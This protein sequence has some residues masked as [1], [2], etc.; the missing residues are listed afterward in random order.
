M[1]VVYVTI[2]LGGEQRLG[3]GGWGGGGREGAA[4]LVLDAGA[5]ASLE[6]RSVTVE[7]YN[8][9]RFPA[10]VSKCARI[11][12]YYVLYDLLSLLLFAARGSG[13]R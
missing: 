4:A 10:A 13:A 9:Q 12:G 8:S 2:G 3:R 1:Y 5:D 7:K 11:R 6:S